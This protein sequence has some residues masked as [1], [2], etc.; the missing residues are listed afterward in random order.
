LLAELPLPASPY[1]SARARVADPNQWNFANHNSPHSPLLPTERHAELK[2]IDEGLMTDK[3]IRRQLHI[4]RRV[5]AERHRWLEVG[6]QTG[7]AQAPH[8]AVKLNARNY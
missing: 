1:E 6:G 2:G 8:A 4:E 3:P 5:A 7:N